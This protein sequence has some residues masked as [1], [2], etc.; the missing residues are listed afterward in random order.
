MKVV[1]DPVLELAERLLHKVQG[2]FLPCDVPAP[3]AHARGPAQGGRRAERAPP[4][5]SRVGAPQIARAKTWVTPGR[6]AAGPS[7]PARGGAHTAC[8]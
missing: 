4:G 2:V 3:P 7:G 6:R 1:P 8:A 5:P